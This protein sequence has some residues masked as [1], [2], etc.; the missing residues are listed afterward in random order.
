MRD[1]SER[2]LAEEAA[3]G[4]RRASSAATPRRSPRSKRASSSSTATALVC[5]RQRVRHP[6]ARHAASHGAAA[7]PIFT[8]GRRAPA[9]RRR[10]FPRRRAADRGRSRT[11][12]GHAPTSSSACAT[13]TAATSG[14]RSA[15]VRSATRTT[16]KPRSSARSPTS[17]SAS[18]CM[19][20]LAWEARHDPLTG[21][22][23]RSGFL[24]AVQSARIASDTAPAALGAVLLRPRPLQA[25]QRLARP[26]CGRR[27]A[28]HRR[29]APAPGHA[30]RALCLSRLHG[31]EFAALEPGVARHRHGAAAR[32]GAAHRLTRAD[33]PLDRTHAHDHPEH[34]GRA[35]LPTSGTDAA[36]LLQDADMAMLQAKTRGRGRV[37]IFDAGL[38]EEVGNRLELEHDLRSAVENGELRLE[39]QP[40]A[41]LASGKSARH[42]GAGALG[43]PRQGPPPAGQLRRPGRGVRAHRRAWA[44]GCSRPAARRWR[45]GGP[46]TP[47]PTTP[48][49]R[50]NVSP[51]QLESQ[52]LLPAL[53]HAARQ[54]RA[55]G[56]RAHARDHR[57][58]PRRR[59]R[60]PPR[61][62]ERAARLRRAARHRRL[63]HRLLLAQLPEAPAREPPEDRPGLR[64]RSRH[65]HRRRADRRRHHRARPRAR[66]PGR[67]RRHR[68]PPAAPR[69]PRDS[70]ATSTRASCWPSRAGPATSPPS[71]VPAPSSPAPPA[72]GAG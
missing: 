26:R 7:T 52:Q 65:R 32:R 34:R 59:R 56:G 47:R 20:R 37:A 62:P 9:R 17:P 71:G 39:Y 36:S 60:R 8:G 55:A 30:R 29:R 54:E 69:G 31:D 67:R 21:L 14:C 15:R 72:D 57:D 38:R 53:E 35:L 24:A 11:R 5:G 44:A 64:E 41:S 46:C 12:R 6:H 45:A 4:P 25:R 18:S 66:A 42:G 27:G 58:G 22:A 49:W 70:A 51:R 13:T 3:P 16:T 33:A 48:S 63:R 40:V 19:D 61:A 2:K 23:N 68:E 50:V 10:A 1:I 28:A 43:A